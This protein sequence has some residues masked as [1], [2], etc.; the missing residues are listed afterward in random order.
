[1]IYGPDSDLSQKEVEMLD[2]YTSGGGKL[3]VMAG[4]TQEDPLD[5]LYGL[6]A[7]YGV[8]PNEGVVVEGDR[9]HY[10]FQVPYIL[11]PD[12]NSPCD[13]RFADR[14]ELPGHHAHRPGTDGVG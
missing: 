14:G 9:E 10:A 4:P 1:M 8:T 7:S 6:I 11:L 5:E 13:Y 12:M 3:L 2:E